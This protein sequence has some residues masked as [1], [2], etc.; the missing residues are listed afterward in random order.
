MP[1]I[2]DLRQRVMDAE[3]RFG[4]INE[5]HAKYSERL[6]GL[7][8]EIE[9]RIRDQQAT[10]ARQEAELAELGARAA[11][12]VQADRENEQLRDMLLSLLRA[13]ERGGGDA[14]VA[15]MRTLD[16]TVSGLIESG[17]ESPTDPVTDS[18]AEPEPEVA[19]EPEAVAEPEPEPEPERISEAVG[20]DAAS[21][22]DAAEANGEVEIESHDAPA[23]AMEEPAMEEVATE[24]LDENE[25]SAET[26]PEDVAEP[27][28]E[29]EPV[30]EAVAEPAPA[31]AVETVAESDPAVATADDMTE[32][33]P[34]A[35]PEVAVEAAV[36]GTPV[37]DEDKTSASLADIMDRVSALVE[38]TGA[39]AEPAAEDQAAAEPD[40]EGEEPPAGQ[41]ATGG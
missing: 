18:L 22:D 9:A 1:G 33:V 37:A 41:A 35:D 17:D 3:A 11:H 6:I 25:P 2:D 14:L 40:A 12:T 23:P 32:A 7:M 16:E 38:E 4:L 26:A 15:T 36:E 24:A 13:I 20:D 19:L 5:Q 27:I 29:D 21:V 30:V 31:E 10:I 8:N 39:L 28:A 34:D